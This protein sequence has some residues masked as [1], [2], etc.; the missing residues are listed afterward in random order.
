MLE[1]TYITFGSVTFARINVGK[2]LPIP[3][4]GCRVKEHFMS[5]GAGGSGIRVIEGLGA[6]ISYSDFQFKAEL[7]SSSQMDA[8]MNMF[9]DQ[10]TAKTL[11]IIAPGL[12]TVTYKTAFT[13]NGLVPEMQDP[14]SEYAENYPFKALIKLH[15]L[16][17]T[18]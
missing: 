18:A 10:D 5:T 11:S 9:L 12:A 14:L 15:I 7:V 13:E 17:R 3:T 16:Q 8:L 2:S 4:P 1:D 6:H